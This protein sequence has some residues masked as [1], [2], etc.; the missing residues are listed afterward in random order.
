MN[1]LRIIKFARGY[2]VAVKLAPKPAITPKF[3]EVVKVPL[4]PPAEP[5][6]AAPSAETSISK[7]T[8]K[9]T[10]VATPAT[11][12]VSPSF[13]L[14][15]APMVIPSSVDWTCSYHGISAKPFSREVQEILM[16]PIPAE[17]IEV[18]TEN[19]GLLYL[20]EIKYRR[21][22][23]KAF[24]PGGWGLVPRGPHSILDN[25]AATS[26]IKKTVQQDEDHAHD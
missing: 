5:E 23:N 4:P 14:D 22:L 7:D 15:P 12:V 20:P 2:K 25:N 8:I 13:D 1:S 19:N 10:P 26:A 21:I 24:G 6:K 11:T 17:D 18:L 3:K 16:A 9:N